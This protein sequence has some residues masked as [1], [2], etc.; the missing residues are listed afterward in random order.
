MR[1]V[2]LD[3]VGGSVSRRALTDMPTPLTLQTLLAGM[4]IVALF[5]A[6]L[7]G[8][9]AFVVVVVGVVGLWVWDMMESGRRH[10]LLLS[11][12]PPLIAVIA[13]AW[14]AFRFGFE[15][16]A[17]ATVIAVAATLVWTVFRPAYRGIRPIAN[18]T[19]AALLGG[20]SAGP[21]VLL[22]MRWDI[23]VNGFLLVVV[24]ALAAATAARAFQVQYPLFDANIAALAGAAVAG[25]VTGLV[26]SLSIAATF[27]A[28][29]AAAGGLVAGSTAGSLLRWDRI[30]LVTAAPGTLTMLDGPLLAAGVYWLALV[31]LTG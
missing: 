14:G 9:R 15:G 16:F 25:L 4:L 21:L 17:V 22:R 31:G 18:T 10:G 5:V 24:L 23:E 29:V 8:L 19:M 2:E 6:N 7:S 12:Y 28:A 30:S 1:D 3:S 27:V 26:S 13:A 20:L 11:P